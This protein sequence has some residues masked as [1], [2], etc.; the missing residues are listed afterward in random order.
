MV[1]DLFVA[2]TA[3]PLERDPTIGHLLGQVGDGGRLGRTE[4]CSPPTATTKRPR[5]VEAALPAS[6]W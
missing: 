5:M 2:Q 3:Y 6:C 1:D 4:T